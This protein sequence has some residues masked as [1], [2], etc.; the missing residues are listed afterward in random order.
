[1]VK[2]NKVDKVAIFLSLKMV[3][4]GKVDKVTEII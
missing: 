1:M 2:V 3:K 4:V